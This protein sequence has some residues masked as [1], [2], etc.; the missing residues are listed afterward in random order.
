MVVTD[1]TYLPTEEELTVPEVNVSG[2][3][4]I[5]A[6]HHLGDACLNE[7]NVCEVNYLINNLMLERTF[8][9]QE[10]MLCRQ[11]LGD[12]RK[13]LEEGKA[14]T[15]CALNFFRQVKRNCAT[16]FTQYVSCIDKSSAW[17]S[18]TP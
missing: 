9:F 14:V 13:C 1:D 10:F 7:N 5:A 11:E 4:L 16:E 2:P 3:V 17:Q 12:A 15:N 8:S 18:F 6:A